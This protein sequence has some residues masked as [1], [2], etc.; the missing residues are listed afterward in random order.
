MEYALAA[1]LI[2]CARSAKSA[3]QLVCRTG[4]REKKM[5]QMLIAVAACLS[6]AACESAPR[7]YNE[8]GPPPAD[9]Y[10][11]AQPYAEKPLP[12]PHE[13]YQPGPPPKVAS[14]GPLKTAM[15]GGYMDNQ[16]QDFRRVLHGTGVLVARPGDDIVLNLRSDDMFDG[17]TLTLSD[18]AQR[19]LS[20]I[21]P[22]LRRYDHTQI[23][24]NGYTDTS[25]TPD[26]NM[27]VSRKRAYTVG[28]Q[29]VKD[30]VPV[31]RLQATGYGETV[32][33]IKTGEGK[34]EPRN[35]RI[36]IRIAARAAG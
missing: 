17:D 11:P 13:A 6:L 26:Q 1:L 20:D 27:M 36:E 18:R 23:F 5:K 4:G 3:P 24:I 30:G 33:K 21:A 10:G 19:I 14:A 35:R 34:K 25:G 22:V 15:V 32:L 8:Y 29:L 16:E 7:H 2:A 28:G 9:T 12:P 31:S